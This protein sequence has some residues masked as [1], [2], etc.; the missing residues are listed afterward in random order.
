MNYLE[1]YKELFTEIDIAKEVVK[2]KAKKA[3]QEATFSSD[4]DTPS[5]FL[6]IKERWYSKYFRID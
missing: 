6:A 1:W 3:L 4:R 5:P 2:K